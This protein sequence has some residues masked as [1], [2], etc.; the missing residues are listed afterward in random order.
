[1]PVVFA[2]P[3]TQEAVSRML[4]ESH[5]ALPRGLRPDVPLIVYLRNDIWAL[6]M[7]DDKR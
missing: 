2:M 4:A 3:E 7:K 5:V 1:M 6:W